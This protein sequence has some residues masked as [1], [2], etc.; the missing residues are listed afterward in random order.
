MQETI[1]RQLKQ[2]RE[3]RGLTLGK[4]VQATHIRAA[5]IEALEADDFESLPSPVQVRAF[6]RLYSEYLGVSIDQLI[7]HQRET[8][9][10]I[11]APNFLPD[12]VLSEDKNRD[13]SIKELRPP[14]VFTILEKLKHLVNPGHPVSSHQE[15]EKSA[16]DP[17]GIKD[18]NNN[19]TQ[20][21][22]KTT[23]PIPLFE[24]T[25]L[26]PTEPEKSRLIL[27]TIGKSL[28]ERRASLSLT[29][30][31]IERHTHIRQHYLRAL[32]GGEFGALPSSVQARG[33]LSNYASFLDLDVDFLLLQYADSLQLGRVERQQVLDQNIGKRQKGVPFNFPPAGKKRGSINRFL[34]LDILV[35]G[36]LILLLLVFAIWATSRVINLRLQTGAQVTSPSISVILRSSPEAIQITS[37]PTTTSFG[38]NTASVPSEETLVLTLP[39]TGSGTVSVVVI[40]RQEAWVRVT[41]DGKVSFEG[42]VKAGTAYPYDGN[43][44]IEVLTGNGIAVSI[45]YNQSNL[46]PMG[47]FGEVVDRIYT[48]KAILVPTSTFTPT[49]SITPTPTRTLRSSATVRSSAT[50]RPTSTPRP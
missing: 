39:A 33:I 6:L 29:L 36:G 38:I 12:Q 43:T 35:G 40:A 7:S 13:L 2:A 23:A 9:E 11:T 5:Q 24:K 47:N 28:Q 32:E 14:K 37:S 19:P 22:I 42:R 16:T 30:E 41:I 46:G 21:A 3:A 49:P 4:V 45:L 8:S 48:S 10:D 34:S 1:G 17:V 27:N 31:E 50:P 44:Q 18:E 15:S 20:D 25:T 26:T